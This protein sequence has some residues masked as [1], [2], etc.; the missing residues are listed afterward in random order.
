MQKNPARFLKR[1][2]VQLSKTTWGWQPSPQV[3]A[4]VNPRHV[5]PMDLLH[6]LGGGGW[7]VPSISE[8][9]GGRGKIESSS[10]IIT[11]LSRP[12]LAQMK[13]KV[14]KGQMTKLYSIFREKQTWCRKSP[15]LRWARRHLFLRVS[16][17]LL[18]VGWKVSSLYSYTPVVSTLVVSPL[19]LIVVTSGELCKNKTQ[20]LHPCQMRPGRLHE[21]FTTWKVLVYPFPVAL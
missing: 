20:C 5:G 19:T 6:L 10:K 15:S 8:P 7:K 2:G 3:R 11:T 1:C 17:I 12:F 4:R 18:G 9:I 14:S 16:S 13:S 21:Y